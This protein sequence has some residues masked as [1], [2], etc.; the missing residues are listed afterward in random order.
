M[1][2]QNKADQKKE[3]AANQTASMTKQNSPKATTN[4]S[5]SKAVPNDKSIAASK[6]QA[7]NGQNSK[8]ALSKEQ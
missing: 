1:Q 4:K 3:A 5:E 6:S 2:N 7:A 8:E